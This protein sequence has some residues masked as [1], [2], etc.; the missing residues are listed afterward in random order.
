MTYFLDFRN[1]YHLKM[2]WFKVAFCRYNLYFIYKNRGKM[3]SSWVHLYIGQARK[4]EL[5]SSR[6]VLVIDLPKL[7][8]EKQYWPFYN[9]EDEYSSC[10]MLMYIVI[11]W[12]AKWQKN[13]LGWD[14]DQLK[15]W[16][17]K[18]LGWDPKFG[19]FWKQPVIWPINGITLPMIIQFSWQRSINEK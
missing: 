13:R 19:N 2:L 18:K 7:Q 16:I 14:F 15:V 17:H 12:A 6:R 5:V 1:F 4:S 8:D 9:S 11:I 10:I 3:G